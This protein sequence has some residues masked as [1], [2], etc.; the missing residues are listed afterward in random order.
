MGEGDVLEFDMEG[1]W[2][3]MENLVKE[4]L[5]RDIGICN[6][7]IKKLNELLSFA[8][9]MP[10]VC[11]IEM[12]PGWRNDKML[13]V[14]KKNNIHVTAYSPLGSSKEKNMINHQKVDRIA[15]KLN[16]SSSQVLVKWANQ[17]GTSAIPKSSNPDRIK[18]N[19]KVFGWQIP[20]P[21]FKTLCSIP[22]QRR[23]VLGEDLFVNKEVGPFMSEADLWVHEY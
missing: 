15:K 3:E 22:D 14:C 6:F 5:V 12:H 17:R 23:V 16:K 1:V 21:D 11:Q 13:Q 7:S 9:T 2:R 4:N 18:R 20:E 8:Q 10:S 19:I